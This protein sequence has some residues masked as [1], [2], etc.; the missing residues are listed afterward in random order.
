[1]ARRVLTEKHKQYIRE[2]FREISARNIAKEFGCSKS[3][4][5]IFMRSEGL[6]LTEE[7]IKKVKVAALRGRTNFTPAEDQYIRDNYLKKPIKVI[8]H[9]IN[10]SFCGVTGRLNQMGLSVPKDLAEHRKKATQRKRG[11]IPFNKG[12]KQTEYMS[13]EAIEKSKS[14]WFKKGSTPHNSLE[15][16]TEV[17]RTDKR[18]NRQYILIKL[19]GERKLR[20][21]HVYVWELHHNMRLPKGHNVVFKDG[22]SLNVEIE[23]LQLLSNEEL[24]AKN[25][26]H[27]Y[28]LE[29][30]ELIHIKSAITRQINKHNTHG[31]RDNK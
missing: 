11:D 30:K 18:A 15:A 16:G 22:N 23:N 12:K 2:N 24:M 26:L 6:K 29:L 5:L 20:F 8:A 1:M 25:S 9:E 17:I 21:K 3:P 27:N 31:K 19:P 28:P 10:R 7:E 4:I 14:T 13:P